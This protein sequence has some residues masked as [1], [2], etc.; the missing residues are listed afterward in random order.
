MFEEPLFKRSPVG[1]DKV[2]VNLLLDTLA[3]STSLI[4][5]NKLEW[6]STQYDMIYTIWL[7]VWKKKINKLLTIYFLFFSHLAQI[8]GRITCQCSTKQTG[9]RF[10]WVSVLIKIAQRNLEPLIVQTLQVCALDTADMVNN[11]LGQWV[12]RWLINNSLTNIQSTLNVS[13]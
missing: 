5:I 11:V 4:D 10:I 2:W 7:F 13:F 1:Q 12:S 6:N 8:K 3:I 9:L